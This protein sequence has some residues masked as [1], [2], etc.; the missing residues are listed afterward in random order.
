MQTVKIRTSQNIEIDYEVAG[1]GDRVLARIIDT[2]V[3]MGLIYVVYII[4]I[5]FFLNV[6]VRL[7]SGGGFPVALIVIGIIYSLALTFYDLVAEIFFNGQSIGK[8]AMKIKV[9]SIE[10]SRPTIGQFFLRWVF[11]LLDFGITLGI[12]AVI[13]VAVSEKKQR[14]GDLIAGTTLIKTQPRTALNEL[15]F[16]SPDDTYEPVFPGV[17]NL[18]DKDITLVHEV[19]SNFK[20]TGNSSLVYNLALRVKE[21]LAID[22]P[23]GMNDFDLLQTV[24]KDY[25]YI[26]SRA[27]I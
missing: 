23:K 7:S 10:G 25:S 20:S 2:G 13:S 26:T 24:V 4:V 22:T 21:H 12:G 17:G 8:Y 16:T 18:T 19:I 5:I 27:G 14:I 11:R 1:L 9:V 3:F 6:F 15:Y